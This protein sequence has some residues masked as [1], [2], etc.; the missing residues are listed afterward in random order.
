MRTHGRVSAVRTDVRLSA[1]MSHGRVHDL[2]LGGLIAELVLP[3]DQW[4]NKCP[5]RTHGRVSAL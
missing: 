1:V 3:E 4:Q 5:V 2:D